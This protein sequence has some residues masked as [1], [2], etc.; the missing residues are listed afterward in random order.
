M[1]I[2]KSAYE[3]MIQHAQSG[4]PH[5]ICGALVGVGGLIKAFRECRNLNT[6][7]AHDRYELDPL[8]F[9]EADDFARA[10]GEEIIG[11]YHSHPDHPSRPSETD[12][13]SAWPDWAYIIISVNRGRFN[14]AR[15]WVIR[16]FGGYF[17]EE[18]LEIVAD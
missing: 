18:P 16:D 7:R 11:I 12:R 13:A 14:D 4:Y 10:R 17:E 3:G 5:E 8:S 1:N 15:N 2:V 9:K 6:E